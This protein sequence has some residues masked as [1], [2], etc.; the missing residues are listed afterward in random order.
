MSERREHNLRHDHQSRRADHGFAGHVLLSG[1]D[2]GE[3]EE[4]EPSGG[5]QA[6]ERAGI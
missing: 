1:L 2:Y 6:G 4:P 5:A 3:G